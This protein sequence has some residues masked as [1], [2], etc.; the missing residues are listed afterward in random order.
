[1][2]GILVHLSKNQTQTW[3]EIKFVK[4]EGTTRPKTIARLMNFRQRAKLDVSPPLAT[5]LFPQPVHE[6]LEITGVIQKRLTMIGEREGY[7][8][9]SR[10]P[11]RN[12]AQYYAIP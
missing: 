10:E 9:S 12:A 4:P 8:A 1:L 2:K 3:A 7:Q 6:F 11:A 5:T